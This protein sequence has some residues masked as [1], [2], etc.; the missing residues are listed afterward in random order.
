MT[1][2]EKFVEFKKW[3]TSFHDRCVQDS[4][5][6]RKQNEKTLE[7]KA[8]GMRQATDCMMNKLEE[9]ENM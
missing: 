3:A 4:H 8:F 6:W 1:D 7:I 2:A 5:Q 9:L